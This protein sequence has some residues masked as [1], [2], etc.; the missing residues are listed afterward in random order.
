MIDVRLLRQT[1][2]SQNSL[3]L[4]VGFS[5]MAGIFIVLQARLM[6]RI[7]D[8]VFLQAERLSGVSDLLW[9]LLLIILCRALLVW[10]GNVSAG[11]TAIAIKEELRQ[12]LVA[13]IISLGPTYLKGKKAGEL[14]TTAVDGIETLDAYFSQYLPQ[15]VISTLVPLTFLAFIFPT[16][17]FSA[18]I[19][20]VT[21][22]LIPLFMWLI[23]QAAEKLAN[24][25]WDTLRFMSGH[26]ADILQ[27]VTTLKQLGQSKAQ[28]ANIARISDQF[29]VNTISVLRV[30]FLSAFIL[31]YLSTISVAIIAVS[32]GLRLLEG[33]INYTDALF[34][35][36]L[37]PEFYLPLRN[38][39]THYHAGMAGRST[40][41][42][43]FA[44][45]DVPVMQK[46]NVPDPSPG[47][48]PTRMIPRMPEHIRFEGV[49]FAYDNDRPVLAD[50]WLDIPPGQIVALVGATGAGKSTVTNLILG[51]IRPDRGRIWIGEL[52]LDRIDPSAWRA[53]VAWVPPS[54]YL[55]NDSILANIRLARPSAT[56]DEVIKAANL[57]RAHEFI[58]S[59]PQGYDTVVNERGARLSRGQVQRVALARAFL[60]DAPLLIMDEPT[61]NLDPDLEA[62]LQASTE[63]LMKDRSALVIAHRLTTAYKADQIVV[64]DKGCVVEAGSH[65]ELV[66]QKGFYYRMLMADKSTGN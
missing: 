52:P 10:F 37:A 48:F 38:L 8:L 5:A 26:F 51:F 66:G 27:G 23:G 42:Q 53:H 40:A 65:D 28:I 32:I 3:I 58:R 18:I 45:L 35:L 2:L 62:A 22:P 54:P 7:I 12:Q 14:T 63:S 43:I 31:E 55:F 1:R 57:A 61:S 15:L 60:K 25:Q 4:T 29:R 44:I 19:L 50:F 24:R 46:S 11:H 17:S 49:Y 13:Q 34:I 33:E 59:L 21:A 6:S 20:L 39:A 47:G 36:I 56:I 9:S 64:L 16:D 30:A 41:S